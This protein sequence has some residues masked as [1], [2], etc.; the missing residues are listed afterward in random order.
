MKRF[1]PYE[2]G[3]GPYKKTAVGPAEVGR[4]GVVPEFEASEPQSDAALAGSSLDAVELLAQRGLTRGAIV[5]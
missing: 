4:Q 5:L 1:K 3:V 2:G